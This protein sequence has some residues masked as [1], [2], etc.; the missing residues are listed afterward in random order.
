[1]LSTGFWRWCIN[2]SITILDIIHHPLVYLKQRFGDYGDYARLQMKP[3][4]L[5]KLALSMSIRY[6]YVGSTWGRTQSPVSE[7]Y[8][9]NKRQDDAYCPELWDL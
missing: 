4:R 7:G 9:L 3:F 5:Q 8:V 6:N 1:M 2:I